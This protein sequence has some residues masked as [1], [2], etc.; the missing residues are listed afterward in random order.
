MSQTLEWQRVTDHFTRAATNAVGSITSRQR[1]LVRATLAGRAGYGEACP[2]LTRGSDDLTAVEAALTTARA[3]GL[4]A[5]NAEP[6]N[7]GSVLAGPHFDLPSP[8]ARFALQTAYLDALGQALGQPCANL[9]CCGLAPAR[10]MPRLLT[11]AALVDVLGPAAEAEAL[12]AVERG[13]RTLKLKLGPSTLPA[14]ER[15]RTRV[16][17]GV[18]LRLDANQSFSGADL[19]LTLARLAR[20]NPE[21]VEELAPWEQLCALGRSP[22]ALALDETLTHEGFALRELSAEAALRLEVVVLK[23]SLLGGFDRAAALAAQAEDLGLD[24]VVSHAYEGEVGWSALVALAFAI[25]SPA[26]AQ[27]LGPHVGLA[28]RSGGLGAGDLLPPAGTG[29]GLAAAPERRA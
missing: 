5:L 23:P 25:G 12:R 3:R 1:V 21:F 19:H 13:A 24:V 2:P 20:S 6:A 15:V 7:L 27:G 22:V 26:R 9:L 4:P 16:G 29:L 17:E 28:P 8:S 11:T 14:V 10:A 18:R